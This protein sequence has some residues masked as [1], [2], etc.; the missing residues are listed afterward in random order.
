MSEKKIRYIHYLKSGEWKRKRKQ[1]REWI[2][3]NALPN[4]CWSCGVNE[5]ESLFHIHH[6]FYPNQ[7]GS[8]PI[9]SLALLCENCHNKLH[10]L[11]QK[12]NKKIDLWEFSNSFIVVHREELGLEPLSSLCFVF[13]PQEPIVFSKSSTKTTKSHCYSLTKDLRSC[14]NKAV[15]IGLCN[16]HRPTRSRPNQKPILMETA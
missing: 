12:I 8:E 11:H 2:E 1:F 15:K 6:R 4:S 16:S 3:I 9:N 13:L 5:D 7:L 10:N 14:K